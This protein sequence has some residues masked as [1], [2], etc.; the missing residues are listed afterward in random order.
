MLLLM[1][2]QSA[3]NLPMLFGPLALVGYASTIRRICHGAITT[4]NNTVC[5][6]AKSICQW[7]IV[8]GLILLS[9]APHQEPRFLLPLIVPLVYLYGREAVGGSRSLLTLWIVFNLACYIF[10]GWLHQGGLIQS[11]LTIRDLSSIRNGGASRHHPIRVF[12]NYKTYMPP[13]FLTHTGSRI[14]R[15]EEVCKI[16]SSTKT[17]IHDDTEGTDVFLDL[18]SADSTVLLAVLRKWLSCPG[19]ELDVGVERYD[20]LSDNIEAVVV[21][22]ISPQLSLLTLVERTNELMIID[23]YSIVPV[24]YYQWH[25]TTEDWPAF[26]GS[27]I[28]FLDQ[29]K[30]GIYAISCT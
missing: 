18:K 12:I 28:D 25:I 17:C 11:L 30:L 5:S 7:T 14:R 21:Y 27:V 20:A 8:F 9:C 22:L 16:D 1:F 6:V 19:R 3:V 24:W 23:Q 13:T 4:S 2:L 29:L 10:F 15:I 26:E